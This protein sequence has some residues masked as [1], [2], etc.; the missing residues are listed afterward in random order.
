MGEG[1]PPYVQPVVP[2]SKPPFWIRLLP[3]G[4]VGVGEGGFV[5][6]GEGIVVPVG[7]GVVV[8]VG[9]GVVVPVG[10]GTGV[11]V[12]VGEGVGTG[13]PLVVKRPG[14]T[15]PRLSIGDGRFSSYIKFAL[16]SSEFMTDE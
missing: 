6:V 16:M 10:V 7:E 15:W 3:D 1:E 2:D 13:V 14:V 4:I 8:I 5:D 12:V 9:D 11:L